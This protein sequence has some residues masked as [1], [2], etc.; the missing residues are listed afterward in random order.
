MARNHVRLGRK[1][2][3]SFNVVISTRTR[4]TKTP[5]VPGPTNA[6]PTS[7]LFLHQCGQIGG[8]AA[9]TGSSQQNGGVLV[10]FTPSRRHNPSFWSRNR[11]DPVCPLTHARRVQESFGSAGLQCSYRIRTG[12]CWCPRRLC[13]PPSEYASILSMGRCLTRERYMRPMSCL[14]LKDSRGP[15][16]FKRSGDEE[17]LEA[18]RALAN[19]IPMS[20]C[21][22]TVQT[23]HTSRSLAGH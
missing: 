16:P 3:S 6:F 20:R 14:S 4:T 10:L 19:Y 9:P 2:S 22:R 23:G 17:P 11:Y 18:M 21:V 1:P 15:R 8:F 5:S 12:T 13:V 7:L